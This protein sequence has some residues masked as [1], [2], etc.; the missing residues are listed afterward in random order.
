[1]CADVCAVVT[2][3]WLCSCNPCQSGQVCYDRFEPY[4]RECLGKPGPYGS[5]Y[6]LTFSQDTDRG[7]QFKV[8]R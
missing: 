3:S 2:K 5:Q 6:T 8:L 7:S 1:M 4:D